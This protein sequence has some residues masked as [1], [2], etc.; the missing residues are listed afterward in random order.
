[1]QRR[2]VIRVGIWTKSDD[3]RKGLCLSRQKEEKQQGQK[4][5]AGP[6]SNQLIGQHCFSNGFKH[7]SKNSLANQLKFLKRI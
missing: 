3:R 7:D 1:M 2:E 5:V 4:E 6:G